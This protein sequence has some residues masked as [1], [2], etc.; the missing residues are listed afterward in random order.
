MISTP[1][2]VVRLM[3]EIVCVG[4]YSIGT[5]EPPILSSVRH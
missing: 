1:E 4:T 3:L 2:N 5:Q